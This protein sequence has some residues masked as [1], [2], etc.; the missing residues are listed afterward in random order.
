MSDPELC[1]A[2][3]RA[4]LERGINLL[5]IY[6]HSYHQP[7]PRSKVLEPMRRDVTGSAR[8][9]ISWS[10]LDYDHDDGQYDGFWNLAQVT[11]MDHTVSWDGTGER[12]A[13][14]GQRGLPVPPDGPFQARGTSA[15]SLNVFPCLHHR[16]AE[17]TLD[18]AQPWDLSEKPSG[19]VVAPLRVALPRRRS[20]LYSRR[21]DHG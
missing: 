11:R 9:G 16:V 18:A 17:E 14:A 2:Q 4:G 15:P 1:A 20:T 10:F 19:T 12:R 5:D 7:S 6:E 3:I 8:L 13:E 21:S